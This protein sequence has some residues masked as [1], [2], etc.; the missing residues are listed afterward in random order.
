MLFTSLE[1]LL[2]FIPIVVVVNLFLPR[3]I[4][5]IWLFLASIFFYAWGEPTFVVIMLVSIFI[6]YTLALKIDENRDNTRLAKMILVLD[7]CVNLGVLFVYKYLNFV[8]SIFHDFNE[9]ISVTEYL[10]PIGISFYTFQAISY[11]V[12]V[13]RGEKAQ[14]NI[15]H[16]GLYIAFFPQLIAG[17]IVRYSDIKEQIVNRKMSF[18]KFSEG[19]FRFLIGFNKKMLLANILAIVAD[20][21]FSNDIN[22]VVMSWLGGICYTLQIYYDFSGYSDMAIGLAKLFGFE[23]HKNFDYPYSS[24]TVTEFWRRWHI[25]LGQWFRDYVYFP[26]GG[27]RVKGK[28]RLVFNLM[29]VWLLTGIWHGANTTFIVWGIV[30]G[31]IISVEKSFMIPKKIDRNKLMSFA[32]R[33]FTMFV[34]MAGWIVFRSENLQ[35]ALWH[36]G[37]L[38]GAR[39]GRAVAADDLFYLREYALFIVTG[40]IFALPV[41]PGLKTLLSK[42]SGIWDG[43][44]DLCLYAANII[45]FVVGV[46]YLVISAHNPFIYFNF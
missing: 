39:N 28:L 36:I 6:N 11:V 5:N 7:L 31:I 25:S 32:Y 14:P 33:L 12:D 2:I 10:L 40:L 45:L 13:Y 3:K 41:I 27:S 20:K 30:Y 18:D 34:V 42:K 37:D 21:A 23:L 15:I 17:P 46:S 43:T 24:G 26:L 4:Q 22:T 16:V 9:D 1:F 38:F 29:L 19:I 44:I 35:V 8:T